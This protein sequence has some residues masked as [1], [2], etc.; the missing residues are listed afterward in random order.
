[1]GYFTIHPNIKDGFFDVAYLDSFPAEFEDDLIRHVHF[2]EP[3]TMIINGRTN[4]G[5]LM[6][7]KI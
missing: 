2:E 7:P 1:V 3:L 4:L 6:K 5:V